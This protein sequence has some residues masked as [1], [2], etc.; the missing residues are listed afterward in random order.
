MYYIQIH[1][2]M[3]SFSSQDAQASNSVSGLAVFVCDNIRPSLCAK[4]FI[5]NTQQ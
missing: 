4:L 5:V 3:L 2:D 1:F